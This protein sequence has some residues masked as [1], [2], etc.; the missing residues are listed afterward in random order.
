VHFKKEKKIHT[1]P[2]ICMCDHKARARVKCAQ[3]DNIQYAMEM[4]YKVESDTTH[5]L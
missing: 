2:Y 5:I 1:A 3:S 4:I